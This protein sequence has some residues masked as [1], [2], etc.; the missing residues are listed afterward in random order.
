M[1]VRPIVLYS[2]SPEVLRRESKPVQGGS[3]S[4]RQLVTD[5][6]DTLLRYPTGVGLAAPQIGVHKRV[7]VVR[8]GGERERPPDPPLAVINPV[9]VESGHELSDYESCLSFPGYFA[10]AVRPHFLRVHAFDEHGKAFVWTLEGFGAVLVHH[11]LDHLDGILL[12][13]RWPKTEK[14]SFEHP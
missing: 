13:D 9:I 14:T 4:V 8:M 1:S 6:K 3:G 2:A 5:L 11:E 10:Q 12:I 7:F